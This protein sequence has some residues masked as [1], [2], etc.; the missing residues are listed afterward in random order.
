[1]TAPTTVAAR[2]GNLDALRDAAKHRI[3]NGGDWIG[4]LDQG[5]RLSGA[6]WQESAQVCSPAVWHARRTGR[7]VLKDLEFRPTPGADM[8]APRHRTWWHIYFTT[9]RF[10]FRCGAIRTVFQALDPPGAEHADPYI[11]AHDVFAALGRS[12]P[13][14]LGMLDDLLTEEDAA[15]SRE[16]LHVLL[17]G[18][19]LGHLL[20]GRA[21]RILHITGLPPLSR[22][23]DPVAL[24]RTAGAL[25][26]LGRH[27]Q[28]LTAIDQA[29]EAL[30]AGDPAVHAD[31]V[32]ERTL[33]TTALDL[34]PLPDLQEQKT[35]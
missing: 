1:M 35:A 26:Q 14:G 12:Q 33:I 5:L 17:H 22:R 16:V 9:L 6:T 21:E 19:W 32:R 13:A 29:I 25:R 2:A 34:T 20:P 31:L 28:A 27:R 8:S 11:R 7:N 18:L 30:P 15:Q 3:N 4:P 24:M 10:D 23:A